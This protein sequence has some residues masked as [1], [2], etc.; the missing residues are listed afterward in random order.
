MYR[1]A[2]EDHFFVCDETNNS[3]D[4]IYRGELNADII[5]KETNSLKSAQISTTLN[6][7]RGKCKVNL[8]E[9]LFYIEE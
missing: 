7:S 1:G 5:F 2:I 3:P 6:P 4:S 9:E 8:P